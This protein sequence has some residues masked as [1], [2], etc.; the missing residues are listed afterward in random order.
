LIPWIGRPGN[1][2]SDSQYA[3][4]EWYPR[5]N[6]AGGGGVQQGA[7]KKHENILLHSRRGKKDY[8][9]HDNPYRNPD[10]PSRGRRGGRG[11]EDEY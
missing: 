8:D 9:R 1:Q 4:E 7:T 5:R 3:R 10:Q 6:F 2:V 11:K